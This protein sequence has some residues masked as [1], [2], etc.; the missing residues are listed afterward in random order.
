M[1]SGR[2]VGFYEDGSNGSITSQYG[3]LY[4]GG[5]YTTIDPAL[6]LTLNSINASGQIVGFYSSSTNHG[7][8]ASR[9]AR[10]A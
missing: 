5:T 3:F 8:L 2:V 1:T 4:S 9:N 6:G 10:K 7:F